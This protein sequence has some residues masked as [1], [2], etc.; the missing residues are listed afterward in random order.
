MIAVVSS[1]ALSIIFSIKTCLGINSVQK[2][3]IPSDQAIKGKAQDQVEP[4]NL[5]PMPRNKMKNYYANV[6]KAGLPKRQRG[7]S[8]PPPVETVG[9]PPRIQRLPN[10]NYGVS[11]RK[12]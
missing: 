10:G 1:V 11:R 8:T 9:L 4:L 7:K 12:K 2:T 5:K 3:D 6:Y